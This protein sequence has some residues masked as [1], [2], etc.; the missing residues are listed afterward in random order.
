MD[1]N[2]TEESSLSSFHSGVS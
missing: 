2:G 1:I